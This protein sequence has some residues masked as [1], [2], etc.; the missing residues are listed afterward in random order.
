MGASDILQEEQV[1]TYGG[2]SKREKN[3]YLLEQ[4]RLTLAKRDYIRASILSS[5]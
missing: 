4:I 3:E 1:E 5:F 2:M